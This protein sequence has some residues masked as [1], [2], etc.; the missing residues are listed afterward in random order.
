MYSGWKETMRNIQSIVVYCG[1]SP[2]KNPN[3]MKAAKG[4]YWMYG[5]IVLQFSEFTVYLLS[6]SNWSGFTGSGFALLC[7]VEIDVKITID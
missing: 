4:K 2:G 3:Y 7:F 1:S 5:F 6:E